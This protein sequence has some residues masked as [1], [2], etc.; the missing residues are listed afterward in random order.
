[1]PPKTLTKSH[2]IAKEIFKCRF[3]P[4]ELKRFGLLFCVSYPEKEKTKSERLS[5]EYFQS[6]SKWFGWKNIQ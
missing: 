2:K 6:I 3:L 5:E 4:K 1:M